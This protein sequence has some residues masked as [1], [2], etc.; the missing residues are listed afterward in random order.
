[1]L[2]EEVLSENSVFLDVSGLICGS[3]GALQCHKEEAESSMRNR[4]ATILATIKI[5]QAVRVAISNEASV[6]ARPGWDEQ[7]F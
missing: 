1:M 4:R 5:A 3:G 6:S 7:E 2:K